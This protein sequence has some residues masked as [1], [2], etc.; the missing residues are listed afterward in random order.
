MTER[1][2]VTT[3]PSGTDPSA[4]PS[5]GATPANDQDINN[6]V[7]Q[8][9]RANEQARTLEAELAE[10]KQRLESLEVSD[11]ERDKRDTISTFLKENK[12]KYPDLEP[13]DLAN[14]QDPK[15][16]DTLAKAKQ[17]RY[18]AIEQRALSKLQVA[19]EEPEP[20]LDEI[21]DKEK[22]ILENPHVED[23]FSAVMD[24][25]LGSYQ[26]K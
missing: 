26:P 19:D 13:E 12:E 2:D 1:T 21:K 25:R 8:R 15:D 14:A 16:L 6:L 18:T 7:S 5:S 9:D 22:K 11:M 24:G 10:A 17:D 20:T 23:K 3:N 4:T